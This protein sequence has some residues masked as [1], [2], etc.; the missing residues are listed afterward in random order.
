RAGDAPKILA[1]TGY[2]KH[3]SE[4]GPVN[5]VTWDSVRW[6]GHAPEGM[7]LLRT[8]ISHD[9]TVEST[10]DAE[11]IALGRDEIRRVLKVTA[12]PLF[13]EGRRWSPALPRYTL[14]HLDRL[15]TAEERLRMLPGLIL[16]GVS[17]RGRGVT[18]AI[19]SGTRAAEIAAGT[20]VGAIA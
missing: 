3:Q 20:I 1:G 12:D 8:F 15:A 17:Y 9:Q 18:D 5:A 2:V 11:L 19:R 4:R 16:A 13:V 10:G 7:A 6:P 14:G